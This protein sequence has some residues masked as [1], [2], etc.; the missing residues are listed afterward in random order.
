MVSPA[1]SSILLGCIRLATAFSKAMLRLRNGFGA[2]P[3]TVPRMRRRI[4]SQRALESGDLSARQLRSYVRAY[5]QA[6]RDKYRFSALI[7][8][9]LRVPWVANHVIG[10]LARRPT[11]ADT[12]VGV[13]GDFL[14][15]K[16]VLSWRFATQVLL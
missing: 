6:F 13:A 2:P 4:L 7:Q 16:L 3:S 10:R 14:S 11:L 5:Q 9:G 1:P 15:P 8:L 12:V